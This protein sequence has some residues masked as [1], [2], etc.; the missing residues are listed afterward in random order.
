MLLNKIETLITVCEQTPESNKPTGKKL[1][2]AALIAGGVGAAGAGAAALAA[3]LGAFGPAGENYIN[4]LPSH[5]VDT[6]KSTARGASDAFNSARSRHFEELVKLNRP[7]V[8]T[9]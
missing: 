4:T 6:V 7:K 5:I 2:K 3:K 1:G 8:Y 9:T